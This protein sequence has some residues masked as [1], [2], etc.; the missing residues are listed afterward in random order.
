LAFQIAAAVPRTAS[1][2]TLQR[3]R[4]ASPVTETAAIA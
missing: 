3:I 2:I 1:V 4:P